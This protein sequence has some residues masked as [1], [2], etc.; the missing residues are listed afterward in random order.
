MNCFSVRLKRSPRVGEGR[1]STSLPNNQAS[2]RSPPTKFLGCLFARI[3]S[4]VETVRLYGFARRMSHVL[5]GAALLASAGCYAR[6]SS[7]MPAVPSLAP[8]GS[9]PAEHSSSTTTQVR[10][11]RSDEIPDDAALAELVGKA[12]LGAF[13]QLGSY[14]ELSIADRILVGLEAGGRVLPAADGQTITW[15]FKY[16]EA[17]LQ[18]VI[19]A[20]KTGRL[21][22]VA[23]VNDVIRLT[24]GKS[25]AVMSVAEYEKEAKR[26]GLEPHVLMFAR[27]NASLKTAY[28]L[29]K[30]WM[31]ANLLGF[32]TSCATRAGA[33]ALMSDIRLPTDAYIASGGG[34][35]PVHVAVPDLPAA[36]VPL[37]K[38]TQ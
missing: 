20:D 2:T 38:F 19:I 28:P 32:N 12:T 26:Y 4:E 3:P 9:Q 27:D 24:H 36:P 31:Q 30:R 1:G 23:V 5:L 7:Q 14:L 35:A 10:G 16:R 29:M 17:N 34:A 21:E 33:C 25:G 18:S 13:L 6:Q 15:G 22:L 11:L 8:Q 37:E